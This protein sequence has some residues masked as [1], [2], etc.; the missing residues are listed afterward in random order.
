VII[1]LHALAV[2]KADAEIAL[3]LRVALLGG[4]AHFFKRL[5]C[6]A[7]RHCLKKSKFTE[8]VMHDIIFARAQIQ[9]A[10]FGAI[11]LPPAQNCLLQNSSWQHN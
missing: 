11:S 7:V 3:R 10:N 1:L 2:L 6:P 4:G 5:P 9:A 8:T